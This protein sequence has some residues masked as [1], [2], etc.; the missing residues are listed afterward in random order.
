MKILLLS[1]LHLCDI[2]NS[3]EFE[4]RRMDK[5]ADFIK[6]SGAGMVLNLGDAVSRKEFL[7]EEFADE[8]AG[9]DYYL[10]WRKQF[11]I[12]FTECAVAREFGFFA[13]KV[14]QQP[15]SF[16]QIDDFMSLIT[17]AP[18]EAFDHNFTLD[19]L[20]FLEQAVSGCRTPKLL[21][22]SH[23]PYPGSCSRGIAPGIFLDIPERLRMLVEE[24]ELDIFW[25]GG[26]FHW[27]AE[28][29]GKFGSLT[30]FYGGRFSNE[31]GKKNGYLRSIDTVSGEI[32]TELPSFW[33]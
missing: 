30:A 31:N 29:A 4:Y 23:V 28:P 10:Q 22:A 2:R 32:N 17:V 21:I 9:F 5:L 19:Q 16:R 25:G 27:D 20:D 14:G 24:S 26:H 3:R 11:D 18:Q 7:R 13:E 1:D 15:D 6:N 8:S 33:W 12:P